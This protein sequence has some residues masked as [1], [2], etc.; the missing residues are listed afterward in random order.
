MPYVRR[1]NSVY[2]QDTGEKVGTS[3]SP[4]MAKRYLRA[5]YAHSND[6]RKRLGRKKA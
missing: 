2:R 4:E 3:S 6:S 1:G 5:L